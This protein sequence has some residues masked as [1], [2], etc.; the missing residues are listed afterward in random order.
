MNN[1]FINAL[2]AEWLKKRRSFSSWLV[3]TGGF[4]VPLILI[5]IFLIFPKQLLGLHASGHFWE[6]LSQ[7]AGS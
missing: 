2:S 5:V 3:I 4:F 6:L 7:K 1:T